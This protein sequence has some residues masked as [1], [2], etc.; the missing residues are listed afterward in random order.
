MSTFATP[1]VTFCPIL[2]HFGSPGFTLKAM[3]AVGH[4]AS[5]Y[6]AKEQQVEFCKG[7]TYGYVDHGCGVVSNDF[8]W[9]I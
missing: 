5:E 8:R 9:R 4:K 2:Q 6:I 3:K 7:K 1:L